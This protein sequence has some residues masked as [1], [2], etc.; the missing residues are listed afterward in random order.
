MKGGEL[1][2]PWL[3]AAVLLTLVLVL[4]AAIFSGEGR[5]RNIIYAL[6]GAAALWFT[7]ALLVR[8]GVLLEDGPA[9]RVS[10][11]SGFWGLPA[12]SYILLDR[13]AISRG[14]GRRL[15]FALIVL[16]PCIFILQG[17]GGESISVVREWAARKERFLTETLTHLRLFLSAVIAAAVI[18][19]PLGILATRN[20]KFSTP[21][22]ALVDGVQTIPSM[23]L[24][25]LLIAPLAALSRNFPFLKTIGISGVGA[26]P[27][28]I[29]LSL[30]AL[31]PIVRNTVAGLAAVP[32]SSLE[33]GNGMGMSPQQ[34][35]FRVRLPMALP[36]L[37]AGLRTASVQ[38]VGN[39]AVAALIGAGGLGIMIFQGLGQAAPDLILLG[40]I[41]LIIMALTVDRLWD[42]IIR[43]T[44]SPG[45]SVR[46]DGK[47]EGAKAA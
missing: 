40:V 16:I 22:I 35:F 38:A 43:K 6:S 33:A 12:A 5:I 31:L 30:Y 14:K 39:A 17:S 15:V 3:L 42:Y 24:F 47:T 7:F 46:I 41:P 1:A 8:G 21:V 18:G 45:L 32:D 26:A 10:P 28:L 19:I 27:A 34:L 36:Y 23:A 29:A 25:G 44:V 4:Y 20:K 2:G 13:A 37:L 11:V 9:P